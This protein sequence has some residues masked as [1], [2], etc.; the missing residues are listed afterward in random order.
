MEKWK[1]V[2]GYEGKYEVSDAGRV[3]SYA[4]KKDGYLLSNKRLN[5]DGYI[6]V[7]FG[8][9]GKPKEFLLNRLVAELFI[10][11]APEG[12]DT[13]NHINGVKTD[14]RVENLEWASR[15][16]QMYHAYKL[17][18]KKPVKEKSIN[19]FT[20]E[21]K[22]YIRDNYQRF[23]HGHSVHHFATLYG[24]AHGVIEEILAEK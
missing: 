9:G 22:A 15:S 3:K 10:G 17:K 20:D 19:R 13:V 7:R 4:V 21:Q 8:G 24:V 11:P 1:W 2:P 6:H 5:A 14:N 16:D 12:K 23:K 18:L